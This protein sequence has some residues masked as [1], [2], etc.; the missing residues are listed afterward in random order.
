LIPKKFRLAFTT[1]RPTERR[2]NQSVH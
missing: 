2:S 1:A